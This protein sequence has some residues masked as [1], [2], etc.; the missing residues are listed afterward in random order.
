MKRQ[1]SLI[2]HEYKKVFS[3][4]QNLWSADIDTFECNLLIFLLQWYLKLELVF[5]YCLSSLDTHDTDFSTVIYIYQYF[6]SQ[7]C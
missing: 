4:F 3:I 2:R 1:I 5:D 7:V 6:N